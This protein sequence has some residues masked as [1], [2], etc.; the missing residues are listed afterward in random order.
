MSASQCRLPRIPSHYYVYCDPPD[1]SGEEV[2]HFVSSQR[3]VKLKGRSFSEFVQQVVPL[4]DGRHSFA[5]ILAEVNDLFRAEDLAAS[6][7]LLLAHGLLEDPSDW[8]LDS[9]AQDRLR[10]QLNLLHDFSLQPIE[11]QQ[12]LSRACVTVFA[13]TGVGTAA[14]RS[15]VAAGIGEVRCV[16]DAVVGPADMYFSPEF[17]SHDRGTLRCDAMRLHFDREAAQVN[18]KTHTAR[19]LDETAIEETI[20]GSDFVINCTDEGNVSLVYKLNRVCLRNKI[21]WIS[22]TASGLEVLVGPTVYPGETACYLCYRMR[23]VACANDPEMSFDFES[24]LDR[25]RS[26]DSSHRANL[27]FGTAMAGQLAGVE[28]LKALIRTDLVATRG[29][30]RVFDL[31]DLSSTMHVVLRKPWCPACFA[32]WDQETGL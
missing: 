28:A 29:R 14:A 1:K 4:L 9:G 20:A 7:D 10:P 21:P 17:T 23:M 31:R 3:R 24:F 13:L 16:D 25:R 22:A 12:R 6:L 11:S 32:N 27:V 8:Q 2:L 19:L 5:E 30:V 26:D 18:L 15:L